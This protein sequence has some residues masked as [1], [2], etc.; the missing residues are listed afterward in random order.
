MESRSG[1]KVTGVNKIR[2]LPAVL[3][4]GLLLTGLLVAGSAVSSASTSGGS[5][6]EMTVTPTR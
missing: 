5:V 2:S 4:P 6:V 1:G 3:L